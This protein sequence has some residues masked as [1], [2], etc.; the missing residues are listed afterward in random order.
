MA[1]YEF[2]AAPAQ[3]RLLVLESMYP[4][5][6]QYHVPF[7]FEVSGALHLGHLA[8]ALDDLVARH[9]ALRT[10]FRERRQVV[11]D[12][13]RVAVQVTDGTR[14]EEI[15]AALR[16]DAARPFDL[17]APPL[18]RCGVYRL[19]DGS[20]RLLL[21]AHH[22]VCDGW[23]VQTMLRELSGFYRA[24]VTGARYEPAPLAVQYPDYAAWLADQPVGEAVEYWRA[25][26]CG[27]PELCALPTDRARPPVQSAAGGFVL[28]D[29]PPGT[30][31]RLAALAR[32]R[33]TT[34]FV[35]MFAAYQAFLSRLTGETDLVVGVPTAGRDLPELHGVVGLLTNTLAVRA[36]V[37]GDPPFAVLVD[38]VRDRLAA[39]V[40]YQDAP[41]GA[42][43]AAVAPQR[44]LSHDP[45][46]QTM[47][48]Y[49]DES[50]FALDLVRAR[51]RRVRVLLDVAKVD[52]HLYFERLG[53]E[54]VG[55][56]QFRADIFD[57][58]TVRH[59]ATAFTRLLD[60]LLSA[61][62]APISAVALA[63][64]PIGVQSDVDVTD[65]RV[66]DLVARTAAARPDAIAL[67]CGDTRLTYRELMARADRLA[68]ALRTAGV[69]A[70]SPVGL[71]LP[72]GVAMGVAPLAVLR[73]GGVYVPLDPELPQAR[74]G[75]VLADL[76]AELVLATPA[77]VERVRGLAVHIGLIAED[78]S[79]ADVP[80]VRG[81]AGPPE[82]A[83]VVHTSG[84]TGAPK[85]VAIPHRALTNLV[86]A[87]RAGF[88]AGPGDRMLQCASFGF[89][90][91]VSDLWFAWVAGAELHIALPDERI[92]D[93]LYRKLATAGITYVGFSPAQVMSLPHGPGRLPELGTMVVGG[94]A[95]PAEVASRWAAPG[96]RLINAYGPCEATVY[97]TMGALVPGRPVTIGRAVANTRAYVLDAR[98]R[99]VPVGVVGEVYVAGRHV[100][101]G[102]VNRPGMTAERFVPD[103]Y[104]APGAVMYRTGDL[105]KVDAAGELRFL[106]R[107]DQQV[108]VRGFR[109]ELGEIE[110]VLMAHPRVESAVVT[111]HGEG[112]DRRLVAYVVAEG[113]G[114]VPDGELRGWAAQRLPG[115][116]VPELLVPMN[117]LPLGRTGKVDRS[118]L[119]APTGRRPD[120]GRPFVPASTPTQRQ[121]A[122]IW[123]RSLELRDVGVHDN[124]FDLGG[125]SVRLLAVLSALRAAGRTELAM[126]TLF[127]Y[128]TIAALAAYLD[129]ADRPPEVDGARLAG[130][131]RRAWQARRH[132]VGTERT[133]R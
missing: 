109:V 52:L 25:S 124:F 50:D 29:L 76:G 6:A 7:A 106:G 73:A 121:L 56:F 127:R 78:G 83:Y 23:S 116:M 129:G 80:A 36:D 37:S 100:G 72:R 68:G 14:P 107:S 59:W 88:G 94:E 46:V 115:Y 79:D 38:R 32:S 92:G 118:R 90:M 57:A 71:C 126:A 97:S 27:A 128:P 18:L 69:T 30:H 133:G 20:Q 16:A 130:A 24:R 122:A 13:A 117:E 21:V 123:A 89:D 105:A 74:L 110:S 63:D 47:F 87:V 3:E 112:G 114:V 22:L 9:E 93:G 131:R 67:V 64:A 66:P 60:G 108:K 101:R 58:A 120:T 49:D 41:F 102:Y 43:V 10:G 8:G 99:P 91:T 1:E 119:P 61:C 19:T 45:V 35:V 34:P 39:S 2:P 81:V 40:P 82:I 48:S 51:T 125:N 44:R 95:C 104:G 103:P 53:A 31:E 96:R 132:P 65:L 84:S 77:V 86:T 98:L 5:S 75:T 4:G 15:D 12:G 17:A 11:V 26:L 33:G 28:V 54:L 113:G 55:H 62:A 111:T 42:V 70:G 85:A